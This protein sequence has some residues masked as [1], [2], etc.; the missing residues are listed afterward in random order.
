M[1]VVWHSFHIEQNIFYAAIYEL[2]EKANKQYNL[3]KR[4]YKQFIEK[5]DIYF[6]LEKIYINKI[7]KKSQ[8]DF[9]SKYFYEINE[10]SFNENIEAKKYMLEDKSQYLIVVIREAAKLILENTDFDF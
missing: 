10:S 2:Y 9:L 7:L 5:I 4:N 6:E 3:Y 1:N 8:F